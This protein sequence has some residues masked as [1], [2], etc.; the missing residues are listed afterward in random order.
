MAWNG[1]PRQFVNGKLFSYEV[2]VVKNDAADQSSADE[3]SIVALVC[4]SSPRVKINS[5]HSFTSYNIKV[6]V[7]NN[8]G[9]GNFSEAVE[10]LTNETGKVGMLH[11]FILLVI[12][13]FQGYLFPIWLPTGAAESRKELLFDTAVIIFVVTQYDL[14]HVASVRRSAKR[15]NTFVHESRG[16]TLVRRFFTTTITTIR[17]NKLFRYYLLLP[18]LAP[19]LP[20]QNIKGYSTSAHSIMVSW[21]PV[22]ESGRNGIVREYRIEYSTEDNII[23][24]ICVQAKIEVMREELLRLQPFSN[25]TI[26]MAAKTVAYGNYSEPIFV[27][28]GELGKEYFVSFSIIII[29]TIH[30]ILKAV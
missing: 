1:I 16:V 10:C 15:N 27:T 23:L 4:H 24:S 30:F 11:S 29:E 3:L 28:S 20:P 13:L 5:L 26:K 21:D 6:A 9:R 25:Y 17:V 12:C 19:T 18:L 2:Y 7:H 22:P 14:I 8:I